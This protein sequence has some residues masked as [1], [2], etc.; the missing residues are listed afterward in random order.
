MPGQP[1]KVVRFPRQ[2]EK[3]DIAFTAPVGKSEVRLSVDGPDLSASDPRDLRAQ[4][5][6][7]VVAPDLKQS[8]VKVGG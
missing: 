5:F 3:V 2:R 8:T 4:L 1:V 6:K 7:L